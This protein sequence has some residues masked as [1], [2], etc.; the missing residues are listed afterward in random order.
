MSTFDQ[1]NI[2]FLHV[3]SNLRSGTFPFLLNPKSLYLW[4]DQALEQRL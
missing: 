2:N 1:A 4:P 3:G